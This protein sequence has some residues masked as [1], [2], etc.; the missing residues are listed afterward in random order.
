MDSVKVGPR[1]RACKSH[2][3][4]GYGKIKTLLSLK[5]PSNHELTQLKEQRAQHIAAFASRRFLAFRQVC[6]ASP[7]DPHRAVLHHQ[8]LVKLPWHFCLA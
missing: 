4:N 3:G 2:D 7:F 1:E 8:G 5:P 6:D